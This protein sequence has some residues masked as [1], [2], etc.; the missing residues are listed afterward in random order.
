MVVVVV[1]VAVVVAA[2]AARRRLRGLLAVESIT[3]FRAGATWQVEAQRR[4]RRHFG[5]E[6][7]ASS[8]TIRSRC[9]SPNWG[10]V[11]QRLVSSAST[12]LERLEGLVFPSSRWSTLWIR[13]LAVW[14][15]SSVY[16]CLFLS[17]TKP[18][19]SVPESF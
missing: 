13:Y 18:T 10:D 2:A 19:G 3:G 4:S 15:L 7:L 16:R 14:R 6:R 1:V 9:D 8:T 11:P 17:S 12:L 5:Q